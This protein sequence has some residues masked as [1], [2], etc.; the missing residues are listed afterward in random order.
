MAYSP[1]APRLPVQPC[2]LLPPINFHGLKDALLHELRNSWL[3]LCRRK[4]EVVTQ[5][6]CRC[7][8]KGTGAVLYE[9]ASGCRRFRSGKSEDRLGQ[10]TL[11][12]IIHPL[13]TRTS[14]RSGDVAGPEKPLQRHLAVAPLPPACASLPTFDV[15]CSKWSLVADPL[16]DRERVRP[17]L[18]REYAQT[19]PSSLAG[20]CHCLSPSQQRLEGEGDQGRFVRPILEEPTRSER[21]PG[22]GLQQPRIKSTKARIGRK[23]VSSRQH[24]DAVDL[25][26]PKPGDSTPQMVSPDNRRKGL[27]KTLRGKGDASGKRGG[28]ALCHVDT[29]QRGRLRPARM[30]VPLPAIPCPH[31][32]RLRAECASGTNCRAAI[33]A[34]KASD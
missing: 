6:L 14:C 12:K 19:L 9:L 34:I 21:P 26:E 29:Y 11:G 10:H 24:V 17:P 30:N 31:R 7:N 13:E 20:V 2:W 3:S 28:E 5:I 22:V 4:P 16:Q 27:T 33:P 8:A 23:V 15:G 1:W 32:V 25:V 18:A